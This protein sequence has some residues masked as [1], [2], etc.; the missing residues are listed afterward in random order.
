MMCHV[1]MLFFFW[2]PALFCIFFYTTSLMWTHCYFYF[3]SNIVIAHNTHNDV[4]FR[5]TLCTQTA[6][7]SRDHAKRKGI[8]VYDRTAYL[9]LADTE[10]AMRACNQ[11]TSLELPHRQSNENASAFVWVRVR[12]VFWLSFTLHLRTWTGWYRILYV[13]RFFIIAFFHF[14][15]LLLCLASRSEII[16]F[17]DMKVHSSDDGSR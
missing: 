3:T 2:W 15:S 10:Y 12:H 6:R 13:E 7:D 17:H 9:H 4:M 14:L 16:K 11:V 1:W 5:R 8:V